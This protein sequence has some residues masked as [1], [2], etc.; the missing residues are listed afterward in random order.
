MDISVLFSLQYRIF[1]I[2][3]IRNCEQFCREVNILHQQQQQQKSIDAVHKVNDPLVN[4]QLDLFSMFSQLTNPSR[5]WPHRG[6]RPSPV[7]GPKTYIFITQ[8]IVNLLI[9][10]SNSVHMN[11][12]FLESDILSRFTCQIF[13]NL[14]HTITK[15]VMDWSRTILNVVLIYTMTFV[16]IYGVK[17]Y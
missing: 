16:C 8:F 7:C 5:Q 2:S 14:R 3:H 12:Y 13:G 15:W 9:Y 11:T 6:Q 1:Y 17:I 10:F 4:Y